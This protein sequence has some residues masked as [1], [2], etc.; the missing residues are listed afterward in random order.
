MM[1]SALIDWHISLN[2]SHDWLDEHISYRA[3][4]ACFQSFKLEKLSIS[5]EPP[6]SVSE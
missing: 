5:S 4:I 3:V 1:V 2:P 6:K